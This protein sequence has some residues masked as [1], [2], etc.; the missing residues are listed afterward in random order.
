MFNKYCK[1]CDLPAIYHIQTW[2][3]EIANTLTSHL[4]L[5][6]GV[7]SIFDFLL[8]KIFTTVGLIKMKDNFSLSEIQM[9]SA[10]FINEARKRGVSFKAAKGPAGYTNY[11]CAEIGGKKIRFES[12]PAAEHASKYEVSLVDC[13]ERTK[14]HLKKGNFPVAE[15]KFFWI[16]QKRQAL[17]Y[18]TD[19]LGF[20]LVVK[21][22]GGSVA[23]HVTTNIRNSEEL[24]KA[25]GKTLAYSPVFVVERL[26]ENS[27]VY[28]ATVVDFDYVAVVKQTPANVVGDGSSTVQELAEKK[29]NEEK[30]GKPH[31]KD[32]TLYKIVTDDMSIKLLAEKN[33]N[34][35]TIPKK[36]ETA[37]LQK[38]PFLKLGGDLEEVTDEVHPEN[39]QLFKNIAKFFD[40]RLVGID[41]LAPEIS[42]S[43]QNQNCAVLELN[44]L[45]CIEMHHFPSSGAPQ[46]V[47]GALVDLFF[48]Y[49]FLK[50]PL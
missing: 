17:K 3:D 35:Q 33:Y 9:R 22:R 40:I 45:P 29:N 27:F 48:K 2:L 21:P 25:I 39:I 4:R 20:P 42:H 31:Q 41:F 47:A 15:G 12:L 26:I 6:K 5:P 44:S 49:Y 1:D 11:F 19:E 46:N 50:P 23:R 34:L 30:R 7:E 16:W 8:E 10:C 37:Y 28:R 32:F 13:K 38:D 18:G 14:N 24:K 43:W 36:G